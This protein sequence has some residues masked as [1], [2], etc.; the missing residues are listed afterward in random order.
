MIIVFGKD[1]LSSQL[2]TSVR[3]STLQSFLTRLPAYTVMILQNFQ[4]S[5]QFQQWEG[6]TLA[7]RRLQQFGYAFLFCSSVFFCVIWLS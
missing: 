5:L 6:V 2:A 4:I 3:L 7:I 1:F